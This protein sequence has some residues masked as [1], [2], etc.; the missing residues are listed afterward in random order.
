MEAQTVV[1]I[2]DSCQILGFLEVALDY[3]TNDTYS[4]SV[5]DVNRYGHIDIVTGERNAR[6][7]MFII[8]FLT[9]Y[10]IYTQHQL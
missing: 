5:G 6:E 3:T 4:V 9:A 7:Y 8:M 1:S 10:V 2:S